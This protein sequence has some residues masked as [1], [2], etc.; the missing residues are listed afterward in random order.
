MHIKKTPL[1]YAQDF[2]LKDFLCA[3]AKPAY[4]PLNDTHFISVHVLYVLYTA[5]LESV[6]AV[7]WIQPYTR[8]SIAV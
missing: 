1:D 5:A 2:K 7:T 3:L 8:C 4:S 6:M